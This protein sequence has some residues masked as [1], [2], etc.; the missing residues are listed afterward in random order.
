MCVLCRWVNKVEWIDMVVI[1]WN[2]EL[3]GMWKK[4]RKF[5]LHVRYSIQPMIYQNL[6]KSRSDWLFYVLYE[7]LVIIEQK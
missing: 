5:A 3:K 2:W 4:S 6:F 1:K 7:L